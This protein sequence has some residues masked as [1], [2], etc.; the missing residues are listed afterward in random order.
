MQMVISTA[1]MVVAIILAR[2]VSLLREEAIAADFFRLSVTP[3][4]HALSSLNA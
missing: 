1:S 2:Q 3:C 4:R